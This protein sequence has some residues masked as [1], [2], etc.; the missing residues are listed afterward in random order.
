MKHTYAICLLLL[1]STVGRAQSSLTFT[2]LSGLPDGGRYGMGYSQDQDAF[3]M[4]GG[5]GPASAFNSQIYRYEPSSDSWASGSASAS[6]TPQ[7]WTSLAQPN[8]SLIYVLNG[9]TA[10]GAPVP[11]LQTVSTQSGSFGS[12]FA[13]PSPASSAGVA[14]WNGLIY[15]YGGQLASGTYT[16]QLRAYNPTSNT[17]TTLAP[18]PEAKSAFG[19]AV[20]GKIYTF[21]GFNGVQNSAR[22]DAYDIS[23]GQWQ[24]QGLL[25]TTVSSQAVAVQGEWVWLV[26]D[27]TNQSYLAAYNVRTRQLR[28][29]TSNLPPRRNAAAAVRNNF[30]YVWG[31]NTASSNAS[32]LA[33]MWRA[34]VSLLLGTGPAT[35]QASGLRAYPNPSEAGQTTL[36]LPSGTQQLNVFDALGRQVAT[37][38]PAPGSPRW[39]LDLRGFPAGIYLVRARTAWGGSASCRVVCP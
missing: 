3:Y 32:T 20:N 35:A 11:D 34:D 4:A 5:G 16:D 1:A 19:A 30:L 33:D 10:A 12:S 18:M 21:G 13:N 29:F 25:P 27:F 14:V 28:T 6:L 36:E 38:T 15:S 9:V 7:R 37:A 26:G 24:A 8:I 23:S 2:Q 31:G 22:V 39:P 17:W